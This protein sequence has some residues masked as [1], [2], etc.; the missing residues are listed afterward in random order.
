ME[1]RLSRM[2]SKVTTGLHCRCAPRWSNALHYTEAE[3]DYLDLKAPLT[4]SIMSFVRIVHTEKVVQ[5]LLKGRGVGRVT[6]ATI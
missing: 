1:R 6:R 5:P 3:Q 2:A 4:Y